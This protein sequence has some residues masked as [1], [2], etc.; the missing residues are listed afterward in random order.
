MSQD[1]ALRYRLVRTVNSAF[2]SLPRK[3]RSLHDALVLLGENAVR[4]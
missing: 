3:I 4:R 2:F 1:V